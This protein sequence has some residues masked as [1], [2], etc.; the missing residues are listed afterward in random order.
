MRHDMAPVAGGIADR[1]QNGPVQ[2]LR[3]IQRLP[4]PGLPVDGIIGMLAQIGAR[5]IG[6]A[7]AASEG[8]AV[9]LCHK[10]FL[11]LRE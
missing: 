3:S 7:V 4:A 5:F 9:E 6:K 1:K 2:F 11:S 10:A 8:V